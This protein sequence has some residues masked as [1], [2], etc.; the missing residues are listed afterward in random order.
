LSSSNITVF[1]PD[2]EGKAAAAQENHAEFARAMPSANF[3]DGA[4]H[5][6]GVA[7]YVVHLGCSALRAFERTRGYEKSQP[8]VVDDVPFDFHCVSFF[9][10]VIG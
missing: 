10:T 8:G 9:C 5:I 4:G 1:R 3:C 2:A 7:S 6:A